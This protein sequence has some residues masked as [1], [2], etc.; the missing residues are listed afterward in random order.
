MAFR[1]APRSLRASWPL[2]LLLAAFALTGMAALDAHRTVRSHRATAERAMRDYASFAAWAFQERLR[3]AFNYMARE[4]L[5]RVNHGES[6]HVPAQIP[7]SRDLAHYLDWDERCGCHRARFGPTP[8]RYFGFTLG[9]DTLGVAL[10]TAIHPERGWL[11]TGPPPPHADARLYDAGERRWINDTLTAR[12][13]HGG[14]SEW[15]YYVVAARRDGV[16][17]WLVAT[18]M[19]TVRGDTIVYGVEYERADMQRVLG[20]IVR[21]EGILPPTF[22]NGRPAEELLSI[23]VMTAGHGELLYRVGRPS[24]GRLE[25]RCALPTS[26]GGLVVHAQMR[27]ERVGDLLIGGLPSARLPQL[28]GLLGLAAGLA[29]VAALQMRRELQLARM[30]TDFVASVSHE[31]RTPLAQMRLLLETLRLGRYRTEEQRRT[32]VEHADRE[33]RRLSHLVDNVLRFG[34]P[35]DAKDAGTHERI[36]LAAEARAIAIEFGPLASSRR[37]SVEVAVACALPVRMRSDALRQILI[38]LLDNAVKYGPAGQVVQV[39]ASRVGGRAR[40]EV[41]DQGPGIPPSEREAVWRP[42]QRG[43]GA[44]RSGAG[45]SG[46]GLTVVRELVAE[47]GGSIAVE[48]APGGG[49]LLVVQLPLADGVAPSRETMPAESAR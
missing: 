18:L 27:P 6:M 46:I 25:A 49:A 33:V 45:G 30:R 39:R 4:A 8:A 13:R 2:A 1:V 11:V 23:A 47:H 44:L 24:A 12:V 17:R 41:R 40:L 35:A 15:G 42:F 14:R 37:A 21:N 36:D 32:A 20:D 19:P 38:N 7:D 5:G 16:P 48:D 9:A 31:L 28:L 10:N 26:Y 29:V 22:A 3:G 43:T 34:S